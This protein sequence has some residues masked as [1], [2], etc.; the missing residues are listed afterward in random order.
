MG[1]EDAVDGEQTDPEVRADGQTSCTCA[2]SGYLTGVCGTSMKCTAYFN[3][4]NKTSGRRNFNSRLPNTL[5]CWRRSEVKA[6]SL[7]QERPFCI[8]TSLSVV[9]H[10]FP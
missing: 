5:E 10:G 7:M 9:Y 3:V 8:V 6:V 2:G 4:S 1:E